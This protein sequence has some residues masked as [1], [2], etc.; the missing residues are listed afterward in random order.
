MRQGVLAGV[1]LEKVGE[2][3]LKPALQS[4]NSRPLAEW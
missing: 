1:F 2:A 4:G 3:N